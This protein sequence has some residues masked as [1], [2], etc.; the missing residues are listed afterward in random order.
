MWPLLVGAAK[1]HSEAATDFRMSS[2]TAAAIRQRNGPPRVRGLTE[3][4]VESIVPDVL[5][6]K[7]IAF[8]RAESAVKQDRRQV[9]QQERIVRID[10]LFL[11]RGCPDALK[12]ALIGFQ[13]A[14]TDLLGGLQVSGLF[15]G[16]QDP[17]PPPFTRK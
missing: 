5:P 10:L 1:T 2:K 8:L 4:N 17:L 14:L 7:P 11:A 15:G 12:R 16:T 9:A 13:N 6:T 3:G